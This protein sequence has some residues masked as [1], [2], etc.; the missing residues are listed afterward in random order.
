MKDKKVIPLIDRTFTL[1]QIR[2]AH[3]Y[4]ETERVKGK[5][6]IKIC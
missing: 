5:V 3:I 2:D 6:V 1:E 4:S